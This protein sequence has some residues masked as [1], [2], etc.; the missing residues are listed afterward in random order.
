LKSTALEGL[1]ESPDVVLKSHG[2]SFFLQWWETLLLSAPHGLLRSILQVNNN[3][4]QRGRLQ[5]MFQN[6][7]STWKSQT[8]EL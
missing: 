6:I 5:T 1:G 2:I 4:K 3:K 7:K 8:Q